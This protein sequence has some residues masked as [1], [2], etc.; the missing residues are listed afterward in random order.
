[1]GNLL[2]KNKADFESINFPLLNDPL[3]VSSDW[4]L[5]Q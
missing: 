2:T 4:K 5:I 1:V 3:L